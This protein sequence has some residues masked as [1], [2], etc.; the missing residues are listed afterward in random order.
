MK[1]VVD[2]SVWDRSCKCC[3]SA[4]VQIHLRRH[5]VVLRERIIRGKKSVIVNYSLAAFF[6]FILE[7]KLV[8]W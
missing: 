1:Y 6:V 8:L 5:H 3:V 4:A 2:D 7:G